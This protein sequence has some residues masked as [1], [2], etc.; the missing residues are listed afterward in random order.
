M[1]LDSLSADKLQTVAKKQASWA[2]GALR[3][4]SENRCAAMAA[5]IAF[6]AAFSLAPT[7]VMVIAISGWFFGA[8]AARGELFRQVHSVLGNDAAAAVTTIVQNAHRSGSAGGVAA[9]ISFVLLAVGASATFS[10]LNSALNIVW[11]SVAPRASSVFALV[12]VRLISFGLVLG[13]AF[14]LIVSLVLDTAITFIGNWIWGD[15]PYVVIG[16]LLQL[17]VGWMVLAFAFAALLKFLPDAPVRWRDALVGGTVAAALF[18]AG[19]K[20]FALYLAHAGMANSFGAAGS[21]AVLLMWL[22]FSAVVLLLGAEFSAARGRMH[23]PRG[24]WGFAPAPPPG[25]RAMLASVLAASTMATDARRG[26]AR[27]PGSDPQ[28]APTVTPPTPRPSIATRLLAKH[29]AGIGKAVSIG[30]TVIEVETQATRAAAVTI[31]EARR[32]AIAA[33]RYVRRHP[34]ESMLI[35]AST[36]MAVAAFARRRNA[37]DDT[38]T[39]PS[40]NAT[41]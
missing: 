19:K 37:S 41:R 36:A 7:L 23:D 27:G 30:K 29:D 14:L 6:Y 31:V 12:R 11:P 26:P 38:E 35:A 13:V 2:A 40:D 9:I 17:A 33:D 4:F 21:L 25:S 39:P 16:N 20:L 22:Y 15:S 8:E 34:W 5:S 18:S 32:R 24:A 1:E 3:Q 28:Q 10:S